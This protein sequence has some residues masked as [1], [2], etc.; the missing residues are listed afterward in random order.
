MSAFNFPA[1]P[2]NGDTY[3]ANGVTFTY[4]SSSTAWQRSSAVGAQGAQG[5]QG[6]TG[7]TGPTGPTGNT[8]AQGATGS[9]GAQGATGSTGAQG[10]TG[11]TGAQGASN[12]NASGA[13]GDFSIAD[14][15]VHTGDTDTAIRFPADNTFRV[16]TGGS[17]RI[18]VHTDGRFRVGCTAQPSGT[19]GGFQLDMGS[20]PGTMRLQSG[21]G[22][23][24]T[25]SASI[26]IGGSNY[27]AN[28]HNGS[29]SGAQLSLTNF[30]TTDGNSTSVSFLNSNQLAIARILGVNISH[31][32][33]N[34]ALVF[35]TSTGTYPTEKM[36]L[37]KDGKLGLNTTDP[38]GTLDVY[39]GTFVL[40]KPNA[41]G[42]ERNWRF[43]NNNVAAGNLGLQVSTAA[44]GSTFSNLIEITRTGRVGINEGTPK[45]TL[46]VRGTAIIAD[47]IGSVPSTFPAPN[48]QLLVY[49]STNGQPIDNVNCARLCIAT[50]A[51]QVGAQGYN[52]AIDFGNSD[53]TASGSS[54]QYNWR[55]A[56]IMSNAAGDT[57]NDPT[58]D[59][60]LQ[61]W[62]KTGSGSL[63]KRVV[64]T[65]AGDTIFGNGI[66]EG[67][68]E[69]FFV[70][71]GG[72]IRRRYSTTAGS[73]IHFT[74]GALMPTTGTGAYNNGGT[75]IGTGSYRWGQIYS[76]SSS[77]STS[78]RTLKNTIQSSDLGLE[79][80]KKLNPVSYKFNDGNSGRTHY[81]L[82]SQDVETVLSNLGK[83][84]IDFGGFC[85]DRNTRV[86]TKPDE[87][88]HMIDVNIE[89][90]GHTYSL[91]YEE[92]IGPLIKA[93]Q[94]LANENIA[95]RERVSNLEGS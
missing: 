77:I 86:E 43:V 53:S 52:G 42:N 81:G 32:S 34:G 62:T 47:D 50:D 73:G 17:T 41:S 63:T 55:V 6:A 21:A 2:S 92:F 60:D 29:N 14:K 1:S 23:S 22:A 74:G 40:S 89:E 82:I 65:Q 12:S 45:A 75:N 57:G 20:Y 11:P 78:D 69:P 35:M 7:S 51:K 36:R 70:E 95:L 48:T 66:S 49:T 72:T 39:D 24:G 44:G 84:G 83:T 68:T 61:F 94:D 80:I 25:T 67:T 19:V 31:S 88:G 27:H 87:N 58:A 85:K 18:D 3:T 76:S 9:T 91:R 64:I 38:I 8:G 46:D 13:T 71:T 28:L 16:E 59:G 90:E 79:F 5:H 37:D 4:S 93:V 15:I 10:A 30:N 26:N 54:A 33:R 56:S